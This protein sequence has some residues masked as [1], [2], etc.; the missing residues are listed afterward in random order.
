M[1]RDKGLFSNIELTSDEEDAIDRMMDKNHRL[2]YHDA[3]EQVLE[4][5]RPSKLATGAID[6][7]QSTPE[8]A[9][10][11]TTQPLP[12]IPRAIIQLESSETSGIQLEFPIN[13]QLSA[14]AQVAE[15]FAELVHLRRE[16]ADIEF[17]LGTGPMALCQ[18]RAAIR[19]AEELRVAIA[20]HKRSA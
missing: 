17:R 11:T 6:I 9:E 2:D 7:V 18:E 12:T 13:G 5:S 8:P 19:T 1:E 10:S 16:F 14:E 3:R 4:Q 15:D 20:K